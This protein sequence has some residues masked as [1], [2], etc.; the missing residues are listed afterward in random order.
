MHILLARLNH[1]TN[2]FSPILPTLSSFS[3]TFGDVAYVKSQ[4]TNTALG[5]F[6]QSCEEN[7]YTFDIACEAMAFP[8][9]ILLSLSHCLLL[10]SPLSLCFFET[11]HDFQSLKI[12]FD[13]QLSFCVFKVK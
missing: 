9:G 10:V 3:P 2:T 4:G 5:G 6:I 8:S 13:T 7:H 12:V 11:L 1:E